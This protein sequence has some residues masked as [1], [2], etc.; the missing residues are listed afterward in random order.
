MKKIFSLMVLA[1]AAAILVGCTSPEPESNVPQG[2]PEDGGPQPAKLQGAGGAGE[3][4]PQEPA[5][6]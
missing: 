1:I 4:A 5:T 6:E 2:S 3:G